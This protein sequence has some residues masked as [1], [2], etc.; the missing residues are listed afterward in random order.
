M[1]E[2]LIHYFLGKK[3]IVYLLTF[4]IV[5]AGAGSLLSFNRELVPKTNLPWV[6]ISVWGGSLPSEEMEEKV[7]KPIEKELKSIAEIE[8]FTSSSKTGS[9]RISVQAREG[10]GEEVKQEVQ[11]IVD[12]LRSGFPRDAKNVDVRQADYGDEFLMLLALSGDD[13][14]TLLNLANTVIKDRIEAV[15]DVKDVEVETTNVSNKIMITLDPE[16]MA[17]YQLTPRQVID[18][19][20]SSNV[21]Q[22]I[23]TLK[24]PGFDTVIEVDRSFKSIQQIGEVPV[25]TPSGQVMLRQVAN[26]QDLRGGSADAVFIRDGSPYI[27]MVVNRAAGSDV[28]NTAAAVQQEIDR[29]NQEARGGYEIS[30]VQDGA[31]FIQHAVTNLSRDVIIGG[32]LAIVILFVFLRNWRITMVISTTI[33]LSVLMTFIGMKLVGYNIDLVTLLSLSLSV[34]LMVD[35]AIV[36]LESIYHFREQGEPL[37][38]AIARGT[39]EVITPVLTS[40]LTIIVVFLPLLLANLGGVEYK[41]IM[42]TIAFTVTIAI[43]SSTVAAVLF[44]PVYANS[45]LGRSLAPAPENSLGARITRALTGVLSLALRHRV[46]TVLLALGLFVAA[47]LLSPLVKTTTDLSVDESYIQARIIMPRGTSLEETATASRQAVDSLSDLPELREIY[48]E[49]Y[50]ERATLHMMMKGKK[51][52]KRSREVVLQEINDRLKSLQYVERVEVGFGGGAG[53]TPV[54]LEV[55]GKEMEII[56][57]ISAQV[58]KMLSAVPGVRN[59]R[60]DFEQGVDKISLVPRAAVLE[61]LGVDE[62]SLVRQLSALMGEQ[63]ITTMSV[64]GLDLDVLARY[65][66]QWM[67]HPDQLRQVMVQ[68]E[69]GALAPLADLVQWRYTKTLMTVNHKEGERVVSVKA[70]LTGSDLGAAGRVIEQQLKALP[71]PAGYSVQMAGALKQQKE[72]ASGVL[73]V[74]LGAVALIYVIMVAQ[75]GRLSHPF[76]IM[77]SLPMAVVGVVVGLVLTQRVVNPI[78]M[79]GFIML[80]GIVVSNAILLIDRINVLRSRGYQL[81]EAIMEAVRNRVRPILMTKLTA[82]LGMLPLALAFAEGS[83]LEAPLATV[84]IFGL[85]FHTLITLILV[86]VLYSLSEGCQDWWDK[87]KNR[88][89][90]PE[91]PTKPPLNCPPGL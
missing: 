65:P 29:I 64:N 37:D 89:A 28:I 46:K 52:Q 74:F 12:R 63:S 6:E 67:Q 7:T 26:V 24:N 50:R 83:D 51:E 10:K 40:Q 25:Q 21:R 5:V 47:V 56:Q 39:R 23:G 17:A 53:D 85:I 31:T 11:S 59:P 87:R 14:P 80:I 57:Q 41:P 35:A 86:P 44:V 2:K 32:T 34:G 66:E 78:G 48:Q 76:I 75:F 8:E 1:V 60:S 79:V 69:S 16:K 72:N 91:Q 49:A 55:S 9:V 82:I 71:V 18:Q 19:L 43:V 15:N 70:E 38:R 58:E 42:S 4:L 61:R 30:K 27:M 77:L 73:Y 22:A 68:S 33:P 62:N 84:V 88:S 54:Q 20:Q 36:V 45:F 81:Q 3:L 90:L 13:L